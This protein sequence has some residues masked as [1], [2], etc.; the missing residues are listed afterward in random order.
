MRAITHIHT[1]HSWDSRLRVE[2]IARRL[3]DLDVSL[4]LVAD[5]DSFDGSIALARHVSENGLAI[6]VPIA[7]EIRTDLGDV[8]A[9]FEDDSH[10]PTIES[11]KSSAEIK[12]VVKDHGGL[13]WL[14]HPYRGHPDVDRI[15]EHCDVIEVFNARCSVKKNERGATLC[16]AVGATPAFGAD[17]HVQKE[18]GQVIV[19]YEPAETLLETLRTAPRPVVAHRA[20]KSNVM[21]AEIINGMKR[22][23]P[24]LVA[25]FILRYAK[26]RSIEAFRA[27]SSV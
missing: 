7:A 27:V 4:A 17:S 21:T 15:A 24:L 16:G 14:P 6:Q 2:S 13:V 10:L 5:H 18:L 1:T 12:T 20:Q 25:Y 26:H 3:S 9:V 11:L 22:R 19:E 8:I 23:R